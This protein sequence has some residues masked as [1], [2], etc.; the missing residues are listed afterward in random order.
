MKRKKKF[1][2]IISQSLYWENI[3]YVT[4]TCKAK[5]IIY[6]GTTFKIQDISASKGS[7]VNEFPTF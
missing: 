3:L 2:L 6:Y 7:L 4:Y 1:P 5:E